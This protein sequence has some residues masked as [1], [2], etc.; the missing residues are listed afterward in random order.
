[1][2]VSLLKRAIE[3]DV[4]FSSSSLPKCVRSQCHDTRKDDPLV[5][6]LCQAQELQDFSK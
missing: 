2:P 1:M 6:T 5:Q 3:I 4:S